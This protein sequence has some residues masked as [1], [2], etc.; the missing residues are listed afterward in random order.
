MECR[1]GVAG[2]AVE[3]LGQSLLVVALCAGP[4][5]QAQVY[6][7]QSDDGTLVLS[8][9]RSAS[10]DELLIAAPESPAPP[11]PP[12]AAQ[13]P[14]T[15]ARR[16]PD[17]FA[18]LIERVAR[19]TDVS[20]RLLHAVIAVE[21]GF[22]VRATSGKGAL[23]LMQLMPQ[24]AKRFGVSDP[25]D[26][27]Q[28]VAG[29]AAYL[30][31]LLGLFND[32]VSLALAAYNAGEGAVIKAGYRIPPYAETRAYVPRVLAHLRRASPLY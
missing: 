25:F 11:A 26:P 5:A 12:Q 31:F 3:K 19:D 18:S 1:G 28:N 2:S 4:A 29:G 30:K 15:A 32:D 9:F 27:A 24:T 6:A 21:S 10:A 16:D 8:N 20:P 14:A 17:R 7:G 13:A 22:D 23:G